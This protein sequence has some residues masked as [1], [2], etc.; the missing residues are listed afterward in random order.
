[1]TLMQMHE[2]IYEYIFKGTYPPLPLIVVTLA[3]RDSGRFEGS[4][5]TDSAKSGDFGQN[6]MF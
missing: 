5:K 1:M 4:P 3:I 6:E 2:L